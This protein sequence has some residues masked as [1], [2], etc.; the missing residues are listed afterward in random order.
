MIFQPERDIIRYG[1]ADKLVVG[2]LKHDSHLI[3][4]II[5]GVHAQFILIHINM[6]LILI[7]QTDQQLSNR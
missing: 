3:A 1:S 2:I 6:S 5:Q 7:Q 4:N